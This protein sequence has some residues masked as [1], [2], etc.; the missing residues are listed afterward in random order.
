MPSTLNVYIPLSEY[1]D[2][3]KDTRDLELLRKCYRNSKY[4]LDSAV[5][6]LILGPKPDQK[7]GTPDA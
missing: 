4:G 1:L 3:V 2:L 5:E 7:E 6:D